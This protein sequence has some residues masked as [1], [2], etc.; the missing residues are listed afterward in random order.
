MAGTLRGRGP[1]C[2]RPSSNVNSSYAMLKM[3]HRK[4][5]ILTA[6]LLATNFVTLGGLAWYARQNWGLHQQVLGIAA[7]AGEIQAIDDLRSGKIRVYEVATNA[8][9]AFTGKKEGQYE[10]W[11]WPSMTA[12]GRP[13]EYSKQFV[14][15]RCVQS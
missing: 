5:R 6:I 3:K 1:P 4:P 10:I 2:K 7:Y 15:A 9:V 11:S 12:Q 13:H 8:A 14:V